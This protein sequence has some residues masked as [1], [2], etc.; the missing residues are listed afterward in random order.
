MYSM[1]YSTDNNQ[2]AALSAEQFAQIPA[3]SLVYKP[4]PSEGLVYYCSKEFNDN[5]LKSISKIQLGSINAATFG[6]IPVATFK[7][8]PAEAFAALTGSQ[9]YSMGYSTDNNQC[10]ALSAEQFAQIP[11]AS[12]VYKPTPSEGL[13]YYCSKELD[14]NAND[15]LTLMS[16]DQLK[17]IYPASF[18]NL[19]AETFKNI[20]AEAFAALTK[21][22]MYSMDY[23]TDNCPEVLSKFKG[24]DHTGD[25][26]NGAFIPVLRYKIIESDCSNGPKPSPGPQP[27]PGPKPSPGPQPSPGPKPHKGNINNRIP[28]CKSVNILSTK[29]CSMHCGQGTSKASCVSKDCSCTC[30]NTVYCKMEASGGGTPAGVIIALVV[31]G[32]GIVAGA[33]YYVY[34]RKK[35]LSFFSGRFDD[36]SYS[37]LTDNQRNNLR[38]PLV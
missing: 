26:D 33:A 4:T 38:S 5:V 23:S 10:A 3:A 15:V 6:N 18:G 21:S 36:N 30:G 37:A 2:C 13:V 22:Q 27:S 24:N 35:G 28:L 31:V 11:A 25:F 8:I 34:V 9:M 16:G 29:M 19:Q 14:G 32:L 1:G 7:N 17:S 20:P 12:L